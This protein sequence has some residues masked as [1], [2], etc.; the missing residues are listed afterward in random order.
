MRS[1]ERGAITIHVAIAL[2]ALLCFSGIVVDQG[3]QYIGRRQAQNGADAAA[4]AGALT[5]ELNA[6]AYTEAVAAAQAVGGQNPIWGQPTAPAD[7]VVSPLPWPCPASAGGGNGCI[8]VDVLRGLT[9][10]FGGAHSNSMPTYMMGLVNIWSQGV[11]A[12]ATAQVAAGNAVQCIKPWVVADKWTDLSASGLDTTGWDQM[13]SWDP[14]VD[15]YAAPGFKATGTPND[16]GLELVLKEG[17]TGTWSSGWT[18]QIDFGVSG[19]SAYQDEIEGC[20]NW[21]PTVGLYDPATSCNSRADENPEKGCVGV[22]TGM[23]QGPTSAGT[24][25][26]IALDS[27]AT[28]NSGTN[29]VQGGCMVTGTCVDT[30]GLHTDISP[31]IVPLAIFDTSTY[32]AAGFTGTNGVARVMNLLG[33]FIEGMC[34]DVYPVVATR[35]PYCGTPAEANKAVVGRLMNYPGQYSGASGSAGP[36]TFLKI[37]RL[38]Q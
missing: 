17:V 35:P 4:L 16:Y 23:A 32:A 30:D 6:S 26:L 2:I 34:N 31:R 22:K 3:A 8:R 25:V 21:V 11:R 27:T 15:T 33:F 36:A 9:D 20:P 19:S 7:V 18:M 38:V 37:T 10:H 28:W 13:D 12:T 14:G 1:P 29:S 5:L 24:G